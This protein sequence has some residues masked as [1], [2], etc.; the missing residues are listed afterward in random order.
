[1]ALVQVMLSSFLHLTY[2]MALPHSK[3]REEWERSKGE[4]NTRSGSEMRAQIMQTAKKHPFHHCLPYSSFSFSA[5]A[6]ISFPAPWISGWTGSSALWF[7]R[8]DLTSQH[9]KALIRSGLLLRCALF[10]PSRIAPLC[11]PSGALVALLTKHNATIS[12]AVVNLNM[13]SN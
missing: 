4:K 5:H 12:S 10:S 9:V 6:L 2:C 11:L 3:E 1:M 13:C 8:E 7:V